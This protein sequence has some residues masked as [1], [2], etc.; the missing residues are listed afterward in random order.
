MKNKWLL[1]GSLFFLICGRGHLALYSL[2]VTGMTYFVMSKLRTLPKS[3]SKK[4]IMIWVIGILIIIWYF[5]V[6][7]FKNGIYPFCYT[8]MLLQNIV[9][10]LTFYQEKKNVPSCLDY[11]TYIVCFPKLLLGPILPYFDMELQNR[12]H[13]KELFTTGFYLFLKGVFIRLLLV[14]H[15]VILKNN[16]LQLPSS[17]LG[18]WILL[19]VTMLI[20]LLFMKSYSNMSVG[21]GNMLGFTWKQE[22]PNLSKLFHLDEFFTSWHISLTTIF[23]DNVVGIILL[24]LSYGMS[25]NIL[26]WFFF[27]WLGMKL[28]IFVLKKYPIMVKSVYSFLWI[29]FSFVFLVR[30]N[31][32][33]IKESFTGLFKT[34]FMEV[35][36][37]YQW[38]SY[39]FLILIALIVCFQ[40]GYKIL[41]KV[42]KN[43]W[44]HWL[45]NI[46]YLLLL[47]L[48]MV[49]LV[50]KT[51]TS[52]WMFRI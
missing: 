18:E 27:I 25:I 3:I 35:N 6:K 50:S 34:P 15:L 42:E 8:M 2:L 21:L 46:C 49:A 12:K 37:L 5:F 24:T 44:F 36:A 22:F 7:D 41:K 16:L 13:S 19:L 29:L 20:V 52:I 14:H 28:E 51:E 33:G 1:I 9:S 10:L 23:H 38:N 31:V 48:S 17:S 39:L 45:R 40:F 43:K 11:L 4:K 26:C 47:I 30:P 32:A